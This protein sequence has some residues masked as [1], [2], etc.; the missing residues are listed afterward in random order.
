MKNKIFSVLLGA[1]S[2]LTS[3]QNSATVNKSSKKVRLPVPGTIIDSLSSPVTEDKLN[4]FFC[5]VKIIADSNIAAGVYDIDADY[6][7]NFAE[8]KLTM[9][10]G[11]ENSRLLVRKGTIPCSFIIGFRIPDDTTFY[12]YFEVDFSKTATKM[13]YIKAYTF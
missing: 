9:P 2:L 7:P 5:S 4:H 11:A 3:C 8:G 6:G 13:Q 12:D 1:G 10:K